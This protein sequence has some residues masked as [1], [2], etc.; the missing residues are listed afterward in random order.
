MYYRSKGKIVSFDGSKEGYA[1]GSKSDADGKKGGMG[2]EFWLL[3][4]IVS[5]VLFFFVYLVWRNLEVGN[6][7]PRQRFGYKFY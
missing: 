6:S 5:L 7:R 2:W 4:S 3:V 1:F